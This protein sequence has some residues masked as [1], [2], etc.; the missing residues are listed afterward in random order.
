MEQRRRDILK[1][2]AIGGAVVWTAPV[3]RS[4]TASAGG[5]VSGLP[6][7][8]ATTVAVVSN[9]FDLTTSFTLSPGCTDGEVVSV[10]AVGQTLCPVTSGDPIP[11]PFGGLT[12]FTA[13]V[14]TACG[15]TVLDSQT[16]PITFDCGA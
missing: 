11:F 3:V 8:F 15:G 7:G 5:P 6:C 14:R 4:G 12:S 13:T 1:K 10:E 16:G 2:A 9:C